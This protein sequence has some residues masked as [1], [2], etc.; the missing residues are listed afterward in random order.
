MSSQ[1]TNDGQMNLNVTFEV[2][3]DLNMAQVLVQKPRGRWA[4]AELAAGSTADRA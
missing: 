3:T 4:T 1:C 2:G